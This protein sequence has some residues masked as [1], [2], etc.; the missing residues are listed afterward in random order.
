[1]ESEIREGEF[2]R[3]RDAGQINA[4]REGK[5]MKKHVIAKAGEGWL[6]TRKNGG[7]AAHYF[8]VARRILGGPDAGTRVKGVLKAEIDEII[9]AAMSGGAMLEIADGRLFP[10]EI[11]RS[12]AASAV[13][14]T[15]AGV[16]M[17]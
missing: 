7:C 2:S 12:Q 17:L 14:V 16:Q 5:S 1:M 6:R 9:L 8:I 4:R 13:F 11:L 3:R 15:A 10:I